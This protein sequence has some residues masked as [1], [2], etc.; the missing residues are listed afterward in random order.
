[1]LQYN[2]AILYLK[3]YQQEMN[4]ISE[5]LYDHFVL[6]TRKGLLYN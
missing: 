5:T 4:F 3:Q 2:N 1:M 6:S